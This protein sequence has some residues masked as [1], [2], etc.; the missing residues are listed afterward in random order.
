MQKTFRHRVLIV[1]LITSLIAN[2][3][4][5]LI[6]VTDIKPYSGSTRAKTSSVLGSGKYAITGGDDIRNWRWEFGFGVKDA[7]GT[8]Q[9]DFQE[10]INTVN[11]GPTVNA[12]TWA[13][14]LVAPPWG[15]SPL[16]PPMPP[17]TSMPTPDHFARVTLTYI[18]DETSI[19]FYET[20][21]HTVTN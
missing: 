14:T 9:P 2:P 8:W 20:D 5:A 16:M 11:G 19:E 1:G 12:S 4:W 10:R 18:Q 13:H 7:A 15:V 21:M 3:A 17:M 6:T